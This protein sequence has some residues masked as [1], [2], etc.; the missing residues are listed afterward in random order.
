M[1]AFRSSRLGTVAV[2]A[3]WLALPGNTSL[4]AAQRPADATRASGS[5]S[6]WTREVTIAWAGIP[7]RKALDDL[8]RSQQVGIVLDRRI[9]PDRLLKLGFTGAPLGD[10]LHAIAT[11]ADGQESEL[12]DVGYIG[13]VERA[14]QLRTLSALLHDRLAKMPPARRRAWLASA[15]LR[16]P[17][18]ATPRQV[19]EQLATD[20]AIVLK[21]ADQLP[22]DLWP[23]LTTPPLP[24]VDRLLL[25]AIQFDRAL[26]IAADGRGATLVPITQPVVLERSYPTGN[27]PQAQLEQWSDLVPDAEL[28]LAGQHIVVRARLEDHERLDA[29]VAAARQSR[30]TEPR[31]RRSPRGRPDDVLAKTR[32]DS[33]TVE[34]KPLDLVLETLGKRLN[35]TIE[36]DRDAIEAAGINLQRLV[37]LKLERATVDELLAATLRSAGLVHERAGRTVHVRPGA[38]AEPTR[39]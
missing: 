27:D 13:P 9:D 16:W 19:L 31:P 38:A 15:P 36:L 30:S 34:G 4:A 11:A 33:F 22:H 17:E 28:R 26:E 37:S 35:L 18:L 14:T 5:R 25:V 24:L 39:P 2:L 23:A 21:G 32:I 7:L 20:G 6:P 10:A 12:G 1:R 8:G 3:F 29:A